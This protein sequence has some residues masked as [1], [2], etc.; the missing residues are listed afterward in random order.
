MKV[1]ESQH[2]INAKM[3]GSEVC[4]EHVSVWGCTECVYVFVCVVQ[5]LW[6][7]LCPAPPAGPRLAHQSSINYCMNTLEWKVVLS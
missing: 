6:A 2:C 1:R 3:V 4:T 7:L 5:P